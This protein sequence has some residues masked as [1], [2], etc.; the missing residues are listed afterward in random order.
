MT[1]DHAALV[2]FLIDRQDWR[3]GYGRGE[4][5]HDCARFAADAVRAQ[6]GKDP[7][8]GLRGAWRSERGASRTLA[9]EGGLEAAVDVRLD[10]IAP[11][12]AGRGDIAL[13]SDGLDGVQLGVIEGD[14]VACPGGSGLFRRHRSEIVAA[15]SAG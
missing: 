6:T 10:R 1:R 9:R 15:W 13:T 4:Q 7:L 5:T 8:R 12:M 11:A 14:T 2:A 3:F